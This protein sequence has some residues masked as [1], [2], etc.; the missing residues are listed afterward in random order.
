MIP[1]G[2]GDKD[3]RIINI[4][5]RIGYGYAK[6][7]S[8]V[9]SSGRVTPKQRECMEGMIAKIMPKPREFYAKR[10]KRSD[11]YTSYYGMERCE[12]DINTSPG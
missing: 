10:P 1:N 2:I 6:F 7:A 12:G 8:S 5:K 11:E 3:R 9:E 4:L